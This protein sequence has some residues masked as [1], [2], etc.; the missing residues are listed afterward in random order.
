MG[1]RIVIIQG[2]PSP[3]RKHLCHALADAYAAGAAAAGREVRRIEVAQLEFPILRTADEWRT[4]AV[5]EGIR[6]AQAAVRW[7]DHVVVMFPLWTG[8]MPALLK[9][10]LEQVARPGFAMRPR[11]DGRGMQPLLIGK[12]A[13]VV[14]TMGMPALLFRWSS[15]SCGVRGLQRATLGSWGFNPVR[16]F[17]I[18]GVD[19]KRFDAQKWIGALREHG[20]NGK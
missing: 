13:R 11:A 10:F 20:A 3:L 4:G 19:E 6:D 16:G 2:H 15:H 9:A 18:G 14:V 17:Y 5:P 7:A 1:K 8:T 12:S